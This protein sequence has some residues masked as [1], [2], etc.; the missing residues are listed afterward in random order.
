M[1]ADIYTHIA[2]EQIVEA[3]KKIQL[4]FSPQSMLSQTDETEATNG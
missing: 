4:I 1:T 2:D 3:A